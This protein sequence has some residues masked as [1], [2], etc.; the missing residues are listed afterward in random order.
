SKNREISN[1]TERSKRGLPNRVVDQP[2]SSDF[3]EVEAGYGRILF[4]TKLS[5][6]ASQTGIS[7]GNLIE[8]WTENGRNYYHFKSPLPIA[9]AITYHSAVYEVDKE[10]YNGIG[11]EH[12]YYL[13]HDLNNQTIMTSMKQTLDYAQQEF[14][15][16]HLDHLRIVEL[17][18][19]W[20][21]GGYA[22]AGTISMVEDNLYLIDERDPT[23][24]SLVA[25]RTIHEVAHQWWGHTLGTKHQAGS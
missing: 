7:V 13:D 25:K 15:E 21:F 2:S 1:N 17:P 4:E 10:E 19:F 9:P 22:L 5:V 8:K 3:A 24:F 20:R 16:Y 6:P 14:G 11:L 23:S 18:S 12:Y